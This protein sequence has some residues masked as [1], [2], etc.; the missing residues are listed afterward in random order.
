MEGLGYSGLPG[1]EDAIRTA[2]GARDRLPDFIQ[3][4]AGHILN[5]PDDLVRMRDFLQFTM[6]PYFS[7]AKAFKT[8]ILRGVSGEDLPFDFR[9]KARIAEMA[10]E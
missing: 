2:V 8:K 4:P 3:G 7:A 9:P 10:E 5:L 1:I 6:S